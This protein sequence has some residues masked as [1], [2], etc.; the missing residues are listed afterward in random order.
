L[1][2]AWIAGARGAGRA[3]DSMGTA[4]AVLTVSAAPPP[5]RTAAAAEGMS[6]GRHVDG[7]HWVTLAGMASS[8]ALVEWFCD[9]FLAAA[10]SGGG[11]ED[12]EGTAGGP[13]SRYEEFAR[14]VE[15][16]RGARGG[17]AA[18]PSGITVEPYLYGRSAPRPDPA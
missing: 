12:A 4:E 3:A 9:R 8:G 1:V 13:A 14:L 18:L 7:G 5:D 16:G 15:R 10:G 2:G 6:W 17:G 11:G